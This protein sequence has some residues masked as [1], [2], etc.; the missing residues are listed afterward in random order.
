MKKIRQNRFLRMMFLLALALYFNSCTDDLEKTPENVTTSDKQFNS[1]E[2]YKQGL[3]S[4]Y[5]NLAYSTFL[6][7]YWSMQEY[8]TDMA[9]S[10]WNDGGD[11][12]YH[13]L[14]WSADSPAITNVYN[15]AI[16]MITLCNNYINEASPDK[17]SAR[18]FSGSEANQIE[19]FKSEARFLRAYCFWIL[20]DCY[21]NPPFPTEETLGTTAPSQIQRADL[22]DFLENEL[23]D[24]ESILAD[25]GTNEWGRPDKAAAWALLARMYVNAKVY[26]GQEHYTEAITYSN[27][28]IDEGYALEDRYEWLMLGDNNLNTNEFIWTINYDNT[29]ITWYSTNFLAL[30]P[31]GVPGSING[32]SSSW[33]AFRFTQQVPALFPTADTSIDKRA[34]FYTNGQ[35]LE[36][37][38]ITTS[39]DGYSAYKYRNKKRDG[40]PIEQNNNFGNISDIDFPVFRL[41]EIY[42]IYAES[43]LR[44]GTGGNLTLALDY[45]NK[46]RGRAYANDPSSTLGNITSTQLTLDFIL[47]ERARELYWE[48]HR[49][50]DLIRYN[51]LTTGDY[52][53]AWKG[54]AE[55]GR[56]VDDKYNLFP[57]PTS[58]LLAN[59]NLQQIEGF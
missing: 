51:R 19:Q 31:A 4:V 46:I 30:G 42:L 33:Q 1:V 53:W 59:P 12:I 43:V 37:N 50:T 15:A 10:T 32:M 56:A 5:S 38:S 22:F 16:N 7:F 24:I 2:G 11:G 58:D 3:V 18:G 28:I 9:V 20:M 57:I 6:R 14:A 52:L 8:T 47:D 54:N 34:M 36:V 25:P 39:T 17:V 40:S 13:E 49:R 21:G 44:G 41:A 48:A 35:N 45:V 23:T 26:T 29:N 55:A 27:R